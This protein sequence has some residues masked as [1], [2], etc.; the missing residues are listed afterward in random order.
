MEEIRE[1]VSTFLKEYRKR[2]KLSQERFS[3][4]LGYCSK[5]IANWEQCK[6]DVPLDILLKLRKETG[7]PLDEILGL[8]FLKE[9]DDAFDFSYEICVDYAQDDY[10]RLMVTR[11]R[12][13]SNVYYIMTYAFDDMDDFLC[14]LS[15]GY[16]TINAKDENNVAVTFD[17][18][19]I[20]KY[21]FAYLVQKEIINIDFHLEKDE[22]KVEYV[23]RKRDFIFICILSLEKDLCALRRFQR[24]QLN[25]EDGEDVKRAIE[26]AVEL[27]K[28]YEDC[29]K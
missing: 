23:M 28:M 2:K 14:A 11:E 15:N 5:S 12:K 3:E 21:Q 27:K 1:S 13:I 6:A 24:E 10:A 20:N 17:E 22:L 29:L 7:S 19:V 8:K 25:N 26:K 4:M 18:D 16:K 9:Y